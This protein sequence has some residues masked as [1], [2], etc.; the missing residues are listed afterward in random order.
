MGNYCCRNKEQ[1]KAEAWSQELN[2]VE[3]P[4][5]KQPSEEEKINQFIMGAKEPTEE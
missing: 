1:V 4:T 3:G 2:E 5:E